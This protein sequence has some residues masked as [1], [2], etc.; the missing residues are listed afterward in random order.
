MPLEKIP[1]IFLVGLCIH[2]TT[3]APTP[4]TPKNERRRDG[5]VDI[6]WVV[7]LIKASNLPH[8]NLH[9]SSV[10]RVIDSGHDHRWLVMTKLWLIEW[11]TATD[12]NWFHADTVDID[13]NSLIAFMYNIAM[14]CSVRRW[15]IQH[16]L[17][18]DNNMRFSS[19]NWWYFGLSTLLSIPRISHQLLCGQT[20][21][22]RG[23]DQG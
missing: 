23:H 1:A 15:I 13:S 12:N 11:G 7:L 18:E 17:K 3:K 10:V 14:P 2:I 19:I 22:E 8:P 20:A 9:L 16:I 4:M 6:N 21:R 5:P